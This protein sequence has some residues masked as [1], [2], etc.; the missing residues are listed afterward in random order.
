MALLNKDQIKAAA[1][2][3]YE[4]VPVPEWGEGAEVRVRSLSGAEREA[5]E[6]SMLVAGPGGTRVARKGGTDNR[7]RLLVRCIVGE[8]G[9]PMFTEADIKDL[10]TKDGAVLDRLVDVAKRLSK[11]GPKAVEE[12]KGNSAAGQTGSSASD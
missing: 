5:W 4:D 3:T 7:A 1:D 2:R 10:N 12:E 8:D 9:E 11:L 6:Q